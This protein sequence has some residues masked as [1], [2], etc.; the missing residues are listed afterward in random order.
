MS[1]KPTYASVLHQNCGGEVVLVAAA[2][3]DAVL[4][5]KK[6]FGTWDTSTNFI[7]FPQKMSIGDDMY[8]NAPQKEES[9]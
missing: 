7:P 1:K 3:N 6:C 2:K 5:C 9:V 4:A 8:I